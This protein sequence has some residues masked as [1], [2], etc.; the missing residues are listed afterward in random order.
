MFCQ[1]F[2]VPVA[3]ELMLKQYQFSFKVEQGAVTET[4]S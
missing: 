3:L 2:Q 1:S 4:F